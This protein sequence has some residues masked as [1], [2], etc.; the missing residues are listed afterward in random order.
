[1]VTP[2]NRKALYGRHRGHGKQKRLYWHESHLEVLLRE[3]RARLC[4]PDMVDSWG[5]HRPARHSLGR[6]SNDRGLV[7]HRGDLRHRRDHQF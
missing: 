5:E 4:W 7:R 1:M 3:R 6:S 2:R